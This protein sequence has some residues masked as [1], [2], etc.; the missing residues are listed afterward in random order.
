VAEA[1]RNRQTG[2]I[3]GTYTG[4][5][6]G[7]G[8]VRP[9]TLDSR[10]RS[11]REHDLFIPREAA[12]DAIDG[13]RVM[14]RP[15]DR[16]TGKVTR[17]LEHGRTKL[18]GTYLGDGLFRPDSHSIP[19][20]FPLKTGKARRGPPLRR[21]CKV[22]VLRNDEGFFLGEVL[23]EARD[24]R[25]EDRAVLEEL[26]I[27]GEFP[28]EVLRE[29][30]RFEGGKVGSRQC[31][32]RLDL[33][34]EPTVVT[35]DPLS[36]RD[37]DDA[38]SIRRK[39]DGGYR[40][41][42][43][44]ADVS[45]YVR[46]GRALDREARLRGLSVYLPTGVVPM[47]PEALSNGL[48]SLREGEDR[49]AISVQLN[50]DRRGTLQGARVARSVIRS[51]RRFTYER[52]SRLME[53][54]GGET[55]EIS[56][57]LK[58]MHRLAGQLRKQRPSL[59]IHEAGVEF[60]YSPEG[61]LVE[62]HTTEGDSAHW[63]IEE[64]MLA[65]NREI[66][67][68]LLGLGEP[69]LFR[70]HPPPLGL[71]GVREFL[72]GMD[73]PG[74]RNRPLPEVMR[75]AEEAGLGAAATSFLLEAMES[76]EYSSREASHHALGFPHYLHFTS[77]IRRYADLTVHRAV[78]KHLRSGKW[79][80]MKRKARQRRSAPAPVVAPDLEE[81]ASHLNRRERAAGYA[82]RRLVRRRVLEFLSRRA[83][84]TFQGVILRVLD[85]GILVNLPGYLISGFIEMGY[86]GAA[87][88]RPGPHRLVAGGKTYHPGQEIL[89]RLRRVDPGRGEL[90]LLPG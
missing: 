62:V 40:L 26:D 16:G 15:G 3:E 90:D 25:V 72:S 22:L 32:G 39:G 45:H 80:E 59:A 55:R 75:R 53:G 86:L 10:K 83:G 65:A 2:E 14:V 84:E 69:A 17:V 60:I 85:R 20:V 13:D 46:P 30:R 38:I 54:A 71:E 56:K 70:H 49:L 8:F 78:E 34:G 66:A 37:F 89:V 76:A 47:L 41:W 29:A 57:L 73:I 9:I 19:R 11:L 64:F 4:H 87:P 6:K 51:D 63:V 68:W 18:A 35:I 52:A 23:G 1:P 31:R 27:S 28:R 21:G 36:A 58:D 44:I 24:P 12:G 7:F 5:P 79:V 82:E 67:G 50:Y 42:V 74:A 43:H 77:P 81:L 33:R 88:R 48:C 61:E